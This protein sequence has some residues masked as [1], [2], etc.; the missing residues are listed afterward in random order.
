MNSPRG[1]SM[2]HVLTRQRENNGEIFGGGKGKNSN[3]YITPEREGRFPANIILEC[4]C[5]EVIK[6]VS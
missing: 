4:I 3:D 6:A 2:Q 1:G 5:D